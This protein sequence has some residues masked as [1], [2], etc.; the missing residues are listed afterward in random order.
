MGTTHNSAQV[1][2]GLISRAAGKAAGGSATM[3]HLKLRSQF[4]NCVPTMGLDYQL[5]SLPNLLSL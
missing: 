4:L 1:Y 2:G 5:L 3:L